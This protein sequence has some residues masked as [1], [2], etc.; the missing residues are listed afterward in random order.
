VA[1]FTRI[2]SFNASVHQEENT[3]LGALKASACILKSTFLYQVY[4]HVSNV[5]TWKSIFFKLFKIQ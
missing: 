1:K 3:P 5:R 4:M 2:I